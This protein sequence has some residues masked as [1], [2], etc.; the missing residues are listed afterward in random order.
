MSKKKKKKKKILDDVGSVI[1][2]FADSK[3]D[4]KAAKKEGK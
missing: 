3:Y 1:V 2:S 4:G